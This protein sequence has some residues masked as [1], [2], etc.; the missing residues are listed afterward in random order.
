MS[1][2]PIPITSTSPEHARRLA[3]SGISPEVIKT[4]GYFTAYT[5]TVLGRLGYS[6]GQQQ[7]PALVIPIFGLKGK[8]NLTQIRPDRPR[9]VK[10]HEAKYETPHGAGLLLD[11]PRSVTARVLSPDVPLF[12]TEGILKADA[13]ATRG[14]ACIASLGVHGWTKDLETW[15]GIPLKGRR[16]LITFDSDIRTKKHVHGAAANLAEF[17]KQR[18]ANVEFI[19]FSAAD[20]GSKVGL[21]DFLKAGQTETE[22]LAL[23]SAELPELPSTGDEKEDGAFLRYEGTERGLFEVVDGKHGEFREALANFDATIVAEMIYV[24]EPEQ[25]REFEIEVTL[26]GAT[27]LITID[28]TEFE[29][30]NWVI[31]KLGGEAR[32]EA[33]MCIKDKVRSAIQFR[34]GVIRKVETYSR[35]GWVKLGDKWGFLHAGGIVTADSHTDQKELPEN[36]CDAKPL[37]SETKDPEPPIPPISGLQQANPEIRVRNLSASL[38]RY[39]LDDAATDQELI[40]AVRISLDFLDLAPDRITFPLYAYLWRVLLDTVRFSLFLA[41]PTG[42]GKTEMSALILQHL[43]SGMDSSHMPE[44]FASTTFSIAATAH[45]ARNVPLV[46]DDFVPKGSYGNI[47]RAHEQVDQL[48]RGLGNQAGRNR[49]NR[50]GSTR[51]GKAPGGG[52]ICSGED[53]PQGQSLGARYLLQ[54]F[55]E[56]DVFDRAD[57][58]LGQRLTA[59]QKL[60]SEGWLARATSGFLRWIAPKYER[61]REELREQK[62]IFRDIFEGGSPH[63]RV[64]DSAAELLAGIEPFLVFAVKIG[65]IDQAKFDSLWERAHDAFFAV[66]NAQEQ[67]RVEQ[68]PVERFLGLLASALATGKA[69]TVWDHVDDRS[70]P[71]DSPILRG[72]KAILRKFPVSPPEGEARSGDE[73]VEYEEKMILEPQGK[74]IGWWHDGNIYLDPDAS[75]AV[76]QLLARD[77]G[78]PPIPFAKKAMGKR[79]AQA[80][81]LASSTKGRNTRKWPADGIERDVWHISA[82]NFYSVFRPDE[83]IEK[84]S[85][86]HLADREEF[87]RRVEGWKLSIKNRQ[88]KARKCL[89]DEF[90]K[91]LDLRPAAEYP[92]A[93]PDDD[94]PHTE[95][96]NV[97]D[98]DISE[99]SPLP[100]PI[101]SRETTTT[102]LAAK[103][104]IRPSQTDADF[105]L[106]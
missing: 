26:N 83:I 8:T 44:S 95:E 1:S 85:E 11:I 33:G 32:I 25:P 61:E 89:T 24:E 52:F 86:A 105:F 63:P 103:V 28:A 56:G 77:A 39:E 5:G 30:M 20:D 87:E 65:A 35:T 43:G 82:F 57:P 67:N 3:D 84:E 58:S 38:S 12:I 29:R 45:Y 68:D 47:Q 34:S 98:S 93:A 18:G 49:C 21:D 15:D 48:L 101:T 50:D 27:F 64:I 2:Q 13:A 99:A 46:V 23:A 80:G 66:L 100:P 14:L 22:L 31:P 59:Y 9:I 79:L 92:I 72:Y 53:S 55:S 94:Q 71:F 41:G 19:L 62:L 70:Y 90:I 51:G 78:Q 7:T 104:M 88:E 37:P 73:A 36:R 102:P 91:L 16:V 76:A 60:A 96:P 40:Q 42:L 10:S 106:D 75:M 97:P 17:L 54:E 74:Q 69:H 81:K 6:R 4:R